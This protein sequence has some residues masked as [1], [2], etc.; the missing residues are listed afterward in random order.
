MRTFL[1]EKEGG[2]CINT[3]PTYILHIHKHK[4][5]HHHQYTLSIYNLHI[6]VSY[7]VSAIL[8]F[9]NC[10]DR[11]REREIERSVHL[12]RFEEEEEE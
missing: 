1:S 7:K 6:H 4:P 9:R 12:V 2:L 8:R 5:I 3:V 11:E 10:I